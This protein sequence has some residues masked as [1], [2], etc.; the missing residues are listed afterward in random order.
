MKKEKK[1][2]KQSINTLFLT[3]QNIFCYINLTELAVFLAT[4]VK[5]VVIL[6]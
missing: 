3:I 6:N 2:S 4:L 1:D 5:L